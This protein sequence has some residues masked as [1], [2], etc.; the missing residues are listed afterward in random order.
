[1]NGRLL[2]YSA[3]AAMA[4]VIWL[5]MPRRAG[6]VDRYGEPEPDVIWWPE[7]AEEG[8]SIMDHGEVDLQHFEPSEFGP[9]W[10]LMDVDLLRKLD[11]FREAWGDQVRISG[12]D[13]ALGRYAGDSASYHNVDRYG[14]VRAVDCFPRGLT[15]DNAEYAVKLA[16]QAGLGG[17]GLYTDTAGGMMMHLDNRPKAGRWARVDGQY[18]GIARAYA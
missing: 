14:R 11:T 7:W 16:E 8:G 1:M 4:G 3:A 5:A 10:S 2:L 17:V 13:G 9:W 18:V 15:P 6:A 12:V